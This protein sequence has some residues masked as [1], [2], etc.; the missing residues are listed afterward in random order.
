LLESIDE[1]GAKLLTLFGQQFK[2]QTMKPVRNVKH[3]FY[4]NDM[5]NDEY[6]D[7]KIKTILKHRKKLVNSTYESFI[8]DIQSVYYV[9]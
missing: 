8:R 2:N 4:A 1:L 5:G 6:F 9:N 7:G 3:F